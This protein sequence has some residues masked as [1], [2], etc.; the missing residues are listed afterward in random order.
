MLFTTVGSN[1]GSLTAQVHS[2]RAS[3][4]HPGLFN[5]TAQVSPAIIESA[6]CYNRKTVEVEDFT[7]AGELTSFTQRSEQTLTSP[8]SDEE[9]S[10][11]SSSEADG[12]ED[13]VAPVSRLRQLSNPECVASPLA[14][15]RTRRELELLVECWWSWRDLQRERNLQTEINSRWFRGKDC[16]PPR[17][18]TPDFQIPKR[19]GS[20]CSSCSDDSFDRCYS[21]GRSVDSEWS[22]IIYDDAHDYFFPDNY[23]DFDSYFDRL[24]S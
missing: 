10:E 20:D 7:G 6:E 19:Y 14:S 2:F 13:S 15:R 8:Q 12:D 24:F 3:S 23:L 4:V 9:R 17:L 11:S 5:T 21:D 18:S 1:S 22:S 16:Y